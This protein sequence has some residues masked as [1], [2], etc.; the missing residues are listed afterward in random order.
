MRRKGEFKISTGAS[1]ILMIFVVLCLTTFAVLSYVTANADS[2][3]TNKVMENTTAYYVADANAQ[4]I[5]ADIDLQLVNL[6]KEAELNAADESFRAEAYRALLNSASFR[7]GTAVPDIHTGSEGIF[8]DFTVPISEIQQ[9][10]VSLRLEEDPFASRV[11][12]RVV[13]YQSVVTREWEED[14]LDLWTG[15]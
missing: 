1:S 15:Q 3:M 2:R 4:R 5:I 9:L 12:Y 6:M 14:G 10:E 8:L 11:R 7:S 13:N